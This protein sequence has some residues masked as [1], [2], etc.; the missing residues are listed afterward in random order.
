ME[1]CERCEEQE[2]R[3]ILTATDLDGTVLDLQR[4]CVRCTEEAGF[5]TGMTKVDEFSTDAGGDAMEAAASKKA[6]EDGRNK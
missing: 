1:P 4:V 2:A 6:A 5:T 3:V